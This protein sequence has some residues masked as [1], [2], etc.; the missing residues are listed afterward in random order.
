LRGAAILSEH[1]WIE[2]GRAL[3]VTSR[4]VQIIQAVF[5]NLTQKGIACRFAITEHTAHT[6]L[7]RL[8]KKLNV[9]T[10]TEL[11]LRVMEQMIALVL[12]ETGVLPP[13]CPRHESGHCCLHK[14]SGLTKRA[15][16]QFP[17]TKP[18]ASGL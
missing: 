6:H 8:F 2:I 4:E 1:A 9:S 13:I 16:A 12:S 3:G 17:G 7:N 11:V 10:R 5:D 14:T 18:V 15:V